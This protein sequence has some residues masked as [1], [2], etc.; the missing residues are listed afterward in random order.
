MLI[1]MIGPLAIATG[2]VEAYWPGAGVSFALGFGAF[3]KAYPETFWMFAAGVLGVTIWS[4]S[5]SKDKEREI[6]ELDHAYEVE[7]RERLE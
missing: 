4:R 2:L 5:N 7:E 3:L 1:F 6:E